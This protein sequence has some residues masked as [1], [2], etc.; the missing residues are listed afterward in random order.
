MTQHDFLRHFRLVYGFDVGPSEAVWHVV[1]GLSLCGAKEILFP[2]LVE[3]RGFVYRNG[4][5]AISGEDIRMLESVPESE[6]DK[7]VHLDSYNWVEV[8]SDTSELYANV[9]D[10][11][12]DDIELSAAE[13]I[14]TSWRMW[15][16]SQ[17]PCRDFVV[18][19][20]TPEDTGGQYGVGFTQGPAR[21]LPE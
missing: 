2:S 15:L 6:F 4:P 8:G 7:R 14:A 1:N 3:I 20:L 13:V 12:I 21:S 9:L 5:S 19:I 11:I 16:P 17:F 10:K 18:S